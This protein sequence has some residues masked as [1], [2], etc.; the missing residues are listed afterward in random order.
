M[1]VGIRSKL[2]LVSFALIAASVIAA[3]AYLTR[4]LDEERTEHIREDLLVR[5]DLIEREASSLVAGL[6][7]GGAWDALADELGS[8]A[9]ARVTLIRRDGL[10]LGDSELGGASLRAVEDHA[11]RPEITEALEQGSGVSTRWSNTVH[12]RMMYAAVPFRQGGRVAGIA[13]LAI[14]L[15]E[16]DEAIGRLR[17]LVLLGSVLALGLAALMSSLVAHWISR[18][19]RGLTA[20]AKRMASGDLAARTHAA[21]R[22]ELAELG[23]A[24]DQLAGSLSGTLGEL[25]A[26][27]DLLDRVLRSMQEGVLLL[28]G[29]G[30]VALANPALRELLLLPPDL[31]GR[32]PLELVRNAELVEALERARASAE[33]VAAELEITGLKPRRLLVRAVGLT[34]GSC[35]VLAVFVDVTDLRRLESLRRDFV[36]NVSHELRTPIAAVLSAAETLQGGAL[37]DPAAAARFVEIVLQDASR[38]RQLVDDLLELSRIESRELRLDLDP[39]DLGPFVHHVLSSFQDRAGARRIRL[40]VAIPDRLPPGRADRRALEQVLANLVDNALKY[41]TE[42]A[43]VTMRAR[44]EAAAVRISVEDTGPGIETRHLA[45]LFERFYRAD[46]GRSRGLGGTGLGLA[47]V[48][49]LVEAMGGTVGVESRVG[50]GTCFSFTLALNAAVQPRRER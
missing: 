43:E 50:E 1:R 4:A 37:R 45:R 18:T 29:S 47:I 15:T 17:Q 5:L 23:R 22:D 27:R 19:V 49:H 44:V 21:G 40:R 46:A 35:G 30:H 2:F 13:R 14:P 16:V 6:E 9:R 28:D 20:A 25:R 10:V 36:A 26:E 32:S 11:G 34:D 8:R 48:K 31:A 12:R 39:I 7:Q 33:P 3:D 38:L 41:C 24:L 42:G